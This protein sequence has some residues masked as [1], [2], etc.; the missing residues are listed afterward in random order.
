MSSTGTGIAHLCFGTYTLL[1]SVG[2]QLNG[3][4]WIPLLSFSLVMFF[5]SCGLLSITF[6]VVAE[7]L[8]VK[9]KSTFNLN[10]LQY[11]Y[12]WIFHLQIKESCFV[13]LQTLSWA[14]SFTVLKSFPYL[15]EAI[16]MHGSSFLFAGCSLGGAIYLLIMLPETKGK[17]C[18]EIVRAL[19]VGG[20][21]DV[22][23][24]AKTI[25]NK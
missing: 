24:K 21:L 4:S 23:K 25:E 2:F 19:D 6:Y 16:G 22:K 20:R 17:S 5:A 9:V 12:S 14:L 10:F 13:M 8:P 18:D 15:C 7:I 3:Y 1:V 11:L